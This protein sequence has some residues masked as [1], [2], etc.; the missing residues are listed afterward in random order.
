M[1]VSI[2]LIA[3]AA[4]AVGLADIPNSHQDK[5]LPKAES[6]GSAILDGQ[7]HMRLRLRHEEVDDDISAGSPI[8]SADRA[9]Q[10]TARVAAG[11]TTG[12]WH[13]FYFR[14]EVE[15]GRP[16]GDDNA[17][18]LDDDFRIPPLAPGPNPIAG[19][20]IA[21]GHA[22]IPDNEFEE[23]NQLYIGWRSH[24][25]GC[26]NSPDPCSGNTSAKLGRQEIIYDNHRWVGNILWRNNFQSYDA[27]RIDNTSIKN[28]SVS[29]SYLNKVKRTFGEKSIFNEWKMD[30]T[31]LINA[32]YTFQD[33]GKLTAYAYLLDFDD[34]P[35]TPFE[36]GTGAA[37]GFIGPTNFDSDTIGARWIGKHAIGDSWDLL[38]E[39]EW[40]NQ[41]PGSDADDTATVDF[42]DNDYYNIELGIRFGGTRVDGLG[43]MP[44][45][46][47]TF[48]IKVGQEVL[49]GQ[50]DGGNALQTPLA[51]FHAFQGWADKFIAPAG[52]TN[53]PVGGIVDTSIN[54]EI[55]GLFGS[56]IGK[57]KINIVYHDYEADKTFTGPNG[58]ISDYGKEWNLLWGKPD[59]FGKNGLL[60][61][62]KYANYSEDCGTGAG[63]DP[64]ICVDTEKFWLMLQYTYQ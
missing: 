5:Y 30:D 57:N 23:V 28:L 33:I 43:L 38:T 41:D 47:P 62:I 48:Q 39:F 1:A 24:A 49:E 37:P 55:L 3:Q 60:G 21:A 2:F 13:G 42:D 51:T 50:G 15:A 64:L 63:S 16:L 40:A 8:A 34:N 17:L 36:E 56:V 20:R 22:V 9:E 61:A 10:L 31:H 46:E 29:Y 52:G 11:W 32:S 27:F 58:R 4:N 7:A 25:G 18:N 6:L 44:I 45:G 12:R 14:G 35:R 26:P 54:L 53:T 19:N 59:L